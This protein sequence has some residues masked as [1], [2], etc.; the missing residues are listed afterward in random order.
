MTTTRREEA[1]F[2][3]D[4]RTSYDAIADD[5]AEM[6]RAEPEGKPLT[7]AMLT[8]FAQ[9]VAQDGGG[10]VVEF[11]SGPGRVTAYLHGLGTDVR[12][13]DL[14]PAMVALARRTYP[15]LR[16]D[17]GSM[18][19]LGG[20]ADGSLRG[21]VA[22][23]SLIHLPPA[24]VPGVLAEF[25]RVLA[26][27]GHLALA[28]QVGEDISRH[29]EAFGHALSL[30]FHRMRPDRVAEQLR[31]AGFEPTATMVREA[32]PDEKTPQAHVL[33]RKPEQT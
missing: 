12:G 8:A 27:G 6:F 5:Y 21:V 17:E 11:G 7:L 28:F 20:F 14:S 3:R 2:L 19:E 31:E 4:T 22:W 23:Y 18:T 32:A 13:V 26:P 16:F 30:D 29:T 1:A 25:H 33:A 10:P 9:T 15:E 24:E